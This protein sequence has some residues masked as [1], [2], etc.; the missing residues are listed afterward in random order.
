MFGIGFSEIAIIVLIVIILIKPDDLPAF[1]RKL[2]R[3]YAKA[4]KAY[5]EV[6]DVKDQFLKEMD[7]AAA[8]QESDATKAAEPATPSAPAT[9]ATSAAPA[10]ITDS[11]TH[12]T[13]APTSV[14][15]PATTEALATATPET[16]EILLGPDLQPI[17]SQ[18][19]A[20][21]E[22]SGASTG[23]TRESEPKVWE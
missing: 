3:L 1:F 13:S 7:I 9:P 22:A 4:K 8:I 17:Q 16:S 19:T 20:E 6:A 21:K 14:E 10:A 12:P 15:T 11:T 23:D 2:G 5:K 18:S